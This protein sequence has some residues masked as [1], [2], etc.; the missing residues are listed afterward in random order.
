MFKRDMNVKDMLLNFVSNVFEVEVKEEHEKWDCWTLT[1][2]YDYVWSTVFKDIVE[3]FDFKKRKIFTPI[4]GDIYHT[5]ILSRDVNYK[6]NQF[7][8][9]K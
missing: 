5:I 8:G 3:D 4:L 6:R 2:F 1:Y 9:K 7:Y